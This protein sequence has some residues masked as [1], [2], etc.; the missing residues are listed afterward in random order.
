MPKVYKN[1]KKFIDPRYFLNETTHRDLLEFLPGESG[2]MPDMSIMSKLQDYKDIICNEK[3][4]FKK[5]ITLLPSKASA[6]AI[7]IAI[8]GIEN[9]PNAEA[10]IAQMITI[11]NKDENVRMAMD[12]GL[13]IFCNPLIPKI[14]KLPF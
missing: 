13:E 1:R 4:A 12:A 8:P 11:Y 2:G 14:P 3:D 6:K 7:M 9:V 5:V 10:I